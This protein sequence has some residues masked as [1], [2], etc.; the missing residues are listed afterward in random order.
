MASKFKHRKPI[1]RLKLKITLGLISLGICIIEIN[2]ITKDIWNNPQNKCDTSFRLNLNTGKPKTVE[3]QVQREKSSC[4]NFNAVSGQ[5]LTLDTNVKARIVTPKGNSF[6]AQGKSQDKL[7][8]T[9]EYTLQIEG[10]STSRNYLLSVTLLDITQIKGVED[11]LTQHKTNSIS[12][13]SIDE[14][15]IQSSVKLQ[16]T[17]EAAVSLAENQGLPTEKLSISLIDLNNISYGAYRERTPRFPASV[18]KL[19]WLVALFGRYNSSQG[20]QESITEAD[21]SKMIQD[22]D[23]SVASRVLD[24]LTNTDSGSD[25]SPNELEQWK[26][27]R[28]LVN[29][30][31]ENAG[32]KDINISQKNF[33]IKELNLASPT[34][35]DKQLRGDSS[36]P[37]RNFLTSH[38]IARLLLEIEQ[39]KA[40]SPT[41][42]Q[43]AKSLMERD[44]D[45]EQ[46][47]QYDSIKGFLGEGLDHNRVQLFSKPGWT[48]DSRQ[49]AAIIYSRDGNARYILVIMG[50]DPKFSQDWR[51]FPKISKVI[52][53][54][55]TNLDRD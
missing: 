35:R 34:G 49:D 22:S 20:L 51:I 6:L 15:Q 41:Y 9:G 1:S 24:S 11:K 4:F 26:N 14:P 52:Y 53:D 45:Q 55:M 31:F 25:L 13:N 19:F 42:S 38:A 36:R 5:L 18:A 47:K 50:D 8:E 28:K 17:V 12:Y 32:Y 23:N 37:F 7:T 2:Q 27:Q 54:R 30:F 16:M 43:R 21:L 39:G 33:P 40:I 46:T 3:G 10:V 44:F 29:Y 48:G